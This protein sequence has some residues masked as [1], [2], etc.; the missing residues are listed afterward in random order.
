MCP[1]V[2]PIL[3]AYLYIEQTWNVETN[4]VGIYLV[5]NCK[6]ALFQFEVRVSTI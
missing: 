3:R 5:K 2:L 4:E 1:Y 6:A